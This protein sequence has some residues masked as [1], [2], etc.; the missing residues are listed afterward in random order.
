MDLSQR[1]TGFLGAHDW[2]LAPI[3]STRVP[4]L[5]PI[6][7]KLGQQDLRSD[8]KFSCSCAAEVLLL[9]ASP[10]PDPHFSFTLLTSLLFFST[11]FVRYFRPPLTHPA[12]GSREELPAQCL[13]LEPKLSTPFCFPRGPLLGLY[14]LVLHQPVVAHLLCSPYE[15]R[16][17]R[18]SHS[19]PLIPLRNLIDIRTRPTLAFTTPIRPVPLRPPRNHGRLPT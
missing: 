16:L 8:L 19:C 17:S 18:N 10:S 5:S 3:I 6:L 2:L 4:P 12:P 15:L 9:L 11:L 13:N 7:K 1:G 14:T